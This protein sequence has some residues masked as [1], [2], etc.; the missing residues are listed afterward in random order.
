MPLVKVRLFGKLG[1]KF[2]RNWE[3]NIASPAEA[4]RAL[5]VLCKGFDRFLIDSASEGIG[6]RVQIDGRHLKDAAELLMPSTRELSI[7]PLPI[8][9]KKGG[10]FQIILGVVLIAAAVITL[11][12]SLGPSIGI[13]SGWG[14]ALTGAGATVGLGAG[15]AF[16]VSMMTMMGASMIF[17]GLAAMFSMP[18]ASNLNG[19]NSE[20]KRS[21]LYEGAV[22]T[23]RQGGPVPVG[24]GTLHVG[25]HTISVEVVTETSVVNAAQPVETAGGYT[26]AAKTGWGALT[27]TYSFGPSF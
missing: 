12:A 14:A 26:I 5:T 18:K 16:A 2:G 1:R 6:Y 24:Y 11:G 7:Y 17:G 13:M 22:G 21:Y 27:V 20:Q 8:G 25:P 23:A 19:G 4:V 3:L 15:T 9:A 10:L